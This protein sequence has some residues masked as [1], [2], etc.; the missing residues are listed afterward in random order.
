MVKYDERFKL[1]VVQSYETGTQGYK[2]V[3]RRYGLDYKMVERWVA[4][5]RQH[6]LLGLR[7]KLSHYSVE[8]KLSVLHRMREEDLSVC[9]APDARRGSIRDSGNCT[10]QYSRW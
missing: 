3:A 8:F 2:S 5:Y 4:L 9:A 6:G 1:S 10:V 7:R